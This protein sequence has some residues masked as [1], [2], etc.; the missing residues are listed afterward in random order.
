MSRSVHLQKMQQASIGRSSAVEYLNDRSNPQHSAPLLMSRE[1]G[2]A[3]G[4]PST[5]D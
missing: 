5:S 4:Q 2:A 1:I 3:C